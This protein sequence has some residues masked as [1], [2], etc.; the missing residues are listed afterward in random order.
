MTDHAPR[1][2]LAS[3]SPPDPRAERQAKAKQLAPIILTLVALAVFAASLSRPLRAAMQ[4]FGGVLSPVLIGCVI[5][6]LFA[7]ILTFFEYRLFGRMKWNGL[8]RGLSL[9][10]TVLTA[11]GSLTLLGVLILPRLYETLTELAGSIDGYMVKLQIWLEDQLEY[12]PFDVN[13]DTLL[14]TS[15]DGTPKTLLQE[16]LDKLS[17]I[18]TGGD[19]SNRIG[20]FIAGLFN[21]FKNVLL[22]LFI[23]F[24]ILASKE[25]RVA[26]IRKA[27]A[28]LF[29]EKADR[30]ATDVIALAHN[31]FGGFIYGKLLDCL[32]V[33]ILTF[34]MLLIF[35]VSAYKALIAMI[36]GVANI[37]PIFGI[38][39]GMVPC[40]LIVFVT[41]PS[42]T[43]LFLLIMFIIQ[44]LD[45]NVLGPK[46][47][48]DNTG[49]SSL[50]V[51]VAIS[52]CSAM[53]G[54]L[55]MILG[56]PV[57]AVVIELSR[58]F[59]EG[60]LEAQGAPTDTLAYY[61][62]DAVGN[63]AEEVYYEHSHLRYLYEQSKLKPK[64][65]RIRASL[66]S[67][68]KKKEPDAPNDTV[69][70]PPDRDNTDPS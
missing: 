39:I 31:T 22:G 7:P 18:V 26:Q 23:S 11:L 12:L 56:V 38:F 5:A 64:I 19:L 43:L 8:R 44:Q 48:G 16:L 58:R 65:D 54:I 42:E 53:W 24:Y 57:F 62:A 28:A 29:T 50:C 66:L 67:P 47:L 51:I 13:L 20:A 59:L 35:D 2:P 37:I 9:F 52:I 6:Y 25:K 68:R 33:G 61:P 36:I 1:P 4:S 32:I 34:V 30:R 45:A 15:A 69:A 55:G 63:A 46:I 3:A 21:T 40:T 27:R 41:S 14:G 17:P 60:R 10:L 49:I 70:S